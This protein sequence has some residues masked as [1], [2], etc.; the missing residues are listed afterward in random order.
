MLRACPQA[1]ML[2]QGRIRPLLHLL[3]Q[4][5]ELFGTDRRGAT[6]TCPRGEV[7]TAA[8]LRDVA[9]NGALSNTKDAGGFRLAHAPLN[10][11]DDS[12][13]KIDR[14]CFHAARVSPGPTL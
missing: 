6:G 12:L 11:L 5:S 1:D 8:I 9:L 14:V 2:C 4:G 13:S 10:C 3:P 7:T